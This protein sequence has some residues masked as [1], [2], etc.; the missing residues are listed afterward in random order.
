MKLHDAV[1]TDFALRYINSGGHAAH[2]ATCR[3]CCG[4]GFAG[5]SL[6]DGLVEGGVA[7]LHH[8]LD[9]GHE[10]L[11]AYAHALNLRHAL[12]VPLA[13]GGLLHFCQNIGGFQEGKQR[14]FFFL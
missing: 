6:G 4:S 7:V 3:G 11:R 1:Q 8:G 10:M 12:A 2:T 9:E 13:A 14:L 5:F